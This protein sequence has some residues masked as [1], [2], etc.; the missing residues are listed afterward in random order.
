MTRRFG[1]DGNLPVILPIY[2]PVAARHPLET[3]LDAWAA[4]GI[5]WFQY[6]H[7]EASD[8]RFWEDATQASRVAAG[9]GVYAMINDRVDVAAALG[10]VGVHVGQSDLPVSV[11]RTLL[12]PEEWI[13]LSVED[14]EQ[15][16][17]G[18][19]DGA[20]YVAVGPVFATGSKAD[21]GPEVGLER[22]SR[23]SA[24]VSLPVVAIGGIDA[25]RAAAVTAA[26]AA[27]VAVI[28]ALL[29]VNDPTT[30]AI[31]LV[32]RARQGRARRR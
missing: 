32:R 28:S 23:I 1:G 21:A 25:S 30:A 20:D 7:K 5:G 17:R 27:S 18:E 6:R 3:M 19:R 16:R 15:A 22:V 14:V 26:G 9:R 31:Q 10:G 11:A 12:G 24:A 8:R 29:S 13:G 4:A 2:D